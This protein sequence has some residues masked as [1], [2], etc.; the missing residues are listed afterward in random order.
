M[1]SLLRRSAQ[2]WVWK[3]AAAERAEYANFAGTGTPLLEPVLS[4]LQKGSE[5]VPAEQ[6]MLRCLI[7]AAPF[8]TDNICYLC[9]APWSL[10]HANW[11][12]AANMRALHELVDPQLVSIASRNCHDQFYATA[13]LPNPL[14]DFPLP[15]VTLESRW[16]LSAHCN[17]VFHAAAF[18]DGSGVNGASHLSRRC[19]WGAVSDVALFPDES[20]AAVSVQN[21][22]AQV[23]LY[24]N[25]PMPVQEVPLAELFAFLMVLRHALL[26]PLGSFIFYTDCSWLVTSYAKGAAYCTS[27]GCVGAGLWQT[28]FRAIGELVDDTSCIK[29]IKV[30]AHRSYAEVASDPEQSYLWAG[31][32]LA[33]KLAKMGAAVHAC[34]KQLLEYTAKA[35][36]VVK[37]VAVVIAKVNTARVDAYGKPERLQDCE[38]PKKFA[39]IT[40]VNARS[41]KPI[42]D[43]ALRWRCCRCIRGADTLEGLRRKECHTGVSRCHTI[44]DSVAT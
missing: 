42:L 29:V 34:D 11:E 19:G 24:G 41:H 40:A 16:L 35:K 32:H 8:C 13:L 27:S 21:A 39:S 23:G 6:G 1:I 22:G 17:P 3:T 10:W 37:D 15:T 44:S 7:A 38:G 4:L 31:N 25:L 12:C 43:R 20:T 9:G 5:L 30:K 18:G 2:N 36:L 28:V 26:D 14:V 33:D